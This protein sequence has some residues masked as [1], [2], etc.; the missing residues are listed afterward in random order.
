MHTF[1]KTE[2]YMRELISNI[3]FQEGIEFHEYT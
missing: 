2:K 3:L 1:K